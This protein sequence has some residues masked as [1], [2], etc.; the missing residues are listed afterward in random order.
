MKKEIVLALSVFSF[1]LLVSDATEIITTD[2]IV[3]G[4]TELQSDTEIKGDLKIT[5]PDS[6]MLFGSDGLLT[7]QGSFYS[8]NVGVFWD[9]QQMAFRVGRATGSE[10]AI[11]WGLYSVGLGYN[12][13]PTGTH[14]VALN[15]STT[16]GGGSALATGKNTLAGGDASVTM[17]ISTQAQ[18]FASVVLGSYNELL[19]GTHDRW[20]SS[21]PLFVIGNGSAW[22]NRRNA[23]TVLKNGRT[24][25]GTSAPQATL[26]VQGTARISGPARIEFVIPQG[27]LSMGPFT[28]NPQ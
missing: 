12:V 7:I 4:E 9:P 11:P 14:S 6:E 5:G 10:W 17:G 23:V 1:A 3:E 18:S 2:L 20:I 28:S 26:D 8:G 22:N 16:A 21:D 25:I 13:K 19:G 15:Q 24:W 27:D